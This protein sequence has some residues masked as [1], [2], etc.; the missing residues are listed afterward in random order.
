VK[1]KKMKSDETK[2]FSLPQL[3]V[4][5]VGIVVVSSSSSSTKK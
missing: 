4:V 3:L 2:Q 5:F 1:G